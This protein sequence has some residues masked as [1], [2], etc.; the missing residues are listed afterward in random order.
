MLA[1][2]AIACSTM[3][4]AG[5]SQE[6]AQDGDTVKV[7]YTGTL[8]DGTVFDSTLNASFNHVEPLEFT[9]G[10]GSLISEFENGV[11]GMS[12]SETRSIHIPA[13][14]AYG[15]KYYEVD[16]DDLPEDLQIGETLYKGTL[17]A[18]VINISESS[19]TL[20]N[21]H[22]LAGFDLN[23]EITLVELIKA[24]EE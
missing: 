3:A 1:I 16:L 20:E 19:A 10:G 12:V 13:K 2:V 18:T 23:F 11:I 9:I 17:E 5:C 21:L 24:D 7:D 8:D 4:L 15:Q 6:T 22:E 14:E